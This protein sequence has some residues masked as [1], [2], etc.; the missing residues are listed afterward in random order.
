M[1]KWLLTKSELL[2][3]AKETAELQ[4]S[5]P[6]GHFTP[7]QHHLKTKQ[8]T[9]IEDIV[10]EIRIIE[11]DWKKWVKADVLEREWEKRS[12]QREKKTEVILAKRGEKFGHNQSKH[13]NSKTYVDWNDISF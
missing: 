8:Q 10:T 1:R 3:A 6:Q 12:A 7:I 13:K 11:N 9:E 5:I 4:L 2:V